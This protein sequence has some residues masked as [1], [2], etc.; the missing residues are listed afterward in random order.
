MLAW[1]RAS[2]P[3]PDWAHTSLHGP[4]ISLDCRAGLRLRSKLTASGF[5]CLAGSQPRRASASGKLE[6]AWPRTQGSRATRS[7]AAGRER[8]RPPVAPVAGERLSGPERDVKA[9]RV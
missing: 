7:C 1:L 2:V 8:P 6:E 4:A 3:H 5:E 9:R